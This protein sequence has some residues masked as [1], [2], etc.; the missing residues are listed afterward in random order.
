MQPVE[1]CGRIYG[2]HADRSEL[3]E[4]I[5]ALIKHSG[6]EEQICLLYE[7]AKIEY[8]LNKTDFSDSY[9]RIYGMV[10]EYMFP[11]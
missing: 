1:H 9:G 7:K 3:E 8:Q 10:M 2:I 6:N 5:R 4:N 11:R